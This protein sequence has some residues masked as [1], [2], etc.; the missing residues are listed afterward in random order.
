MNSQQLRDIYLCGMI[1]CK[2]EK[3]AFHCLASRTDALRGVF[4]SLSGEEGVEHGTH[5]ELLNPPS[6]SLPAVTDTFQCS[7]TSEH[8]YTGQR[9][10]RSSFIRV[11]ECQLEFS[12]EDYIFSMNRPKEKLT[13][14][15][16]RSIRSSFDSS[17]VTGNISSDE[18]TKELSGIGWTFFPHNLS[19][20]KGVDINLFFR[21]GDV[22]FFVSYRYDSDILCDA[23]WK[24]HSPDFEQHGQTSVLHLSRWMSPRT[25]QSYPTVIEFAVEEF[26]FKFHLQCSLL[27]QEVETIFSDGNGQF[28]CCFSGYRSRGE[29]AEAF[30]GV[31]FGLGT[32]RLSVEAAMK[33]VGKIVTDNLPHKLRFN[34]DPRVDAVLFDAVFAPVEELIKRGGKS[35]RGF[36]FCVLCNLFP[37]RDFNYANYVEAIE[38][39]HVGSLAIDD[40]EDN[41]TERRGGPCVHRTY[42]VPTVINSGC[43]CFFSAL[44]LIDME[45]L[46]TAKSLL[47]H[48]TTMEMLRLSHVGQGLDI[49]GVMEALKHSDSLDPVE[50]VEC[51][52]SFKTGEFISYIC[53]LACILT[54]VSNELHEKMATFGRTIG[55]AFQI[56]DDL[57]DILYPDRISHFAED[58]RAG[59]VTFP[60][61]YALKELPGSERDSLFSLLS[62]QTNDLQQVRRVI[63]T[64]TSTNAI[65]AARRMVHEKIQHARETLF[66]FLPSSTSKEFLS[67]MCDSMIDI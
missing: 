60:L 8:E 14:I 36:L 20:L 10:E 52:H 51:T 66:P 64:I 9:F 43:S 1:S 40:I 44:R 33:Q 11:R 55:I 31:I 50:Y 21:I 54:D 48:R 18:E 7:N 5:V 16:T 56:N 4:W 26:D 25:F 47:I 39:L 63:A 12:A 59:K 13:L 3:F 6:D 35:W 65:N 23:E 37:H 58:I 22:D 34:V 19:P 2:E 57:R 38:L 62:S 30:E 41:S 42:G 29:K 28:C 46:P 17:Y 15:F 24:C 49:Y 45:S 67:T 53:S 27:N 32:S 61:A